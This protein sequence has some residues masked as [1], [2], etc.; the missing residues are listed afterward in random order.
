MSVKKYRKM[1]WLV[2]IMLLTAGCGA[3]EK[4]AVNKVE[5]IIAKN[6]HGPTT[7]VEAMWN[8]DYTLFTNLETI[9]NDM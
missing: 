2:T 1:A 7:T 6:R 9:R 5:F 4:P 8:G 3:A